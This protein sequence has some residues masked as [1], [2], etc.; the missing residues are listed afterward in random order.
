RQLGLDVL[1]G[2]PDQQLTQL[3]HR[4]LQVC[5]TGGLAARRSVQFRDRFTPLDVAPAARSPRG[6]GRPGALEPAHRTRAILAELL[7]M[8]AAA[9][10]QS[11]TSATPSWTTPNAG[12]VSPLT[13]QKPAA[14]G[15]PSARHPRASTPPRAAWKAPRSTPVPAQYAKTPIPTVSI[16]ITLLLSPCE[17]KGRVR[18]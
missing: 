17:T 16:T 7:P 11:P 2:L 9:V 10:Q 6:R 4:H 14:S 3:F 12:A 13:R 1:H 15:L 18:P 5:G 8:A